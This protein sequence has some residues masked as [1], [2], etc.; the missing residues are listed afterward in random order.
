MARTCRRPGRVTPPGIRRRR[1][2]STSTS[3]T[4]TTS[5]TR[6]WRPDST[7]RPP[8][9]SCPTAACS[10]ASSREDQGAASAV[11]PG[12]PGLFL[13]ITNIGSAG[14]QQGIYDIVL[15]PGFSTNHFYYV[16]YTLGSPNH[17]RVSR[18]TANAALSTVAG[19]FVLYEDPQDAHAE[20]HGGALNFANDGKLLFTTGEHFVPRLRS[21]SRTRAARCTASTRTG[22]CRPTTCSTTAPG[23]TSTPSGREAC[24]TS[25]GP[26]TTRRPAASSATSAATIRRP[27]RRRSTSACTR[28]GLR[29][30]QQ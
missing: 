25:S 20:H 13:Q 5:R 24:A 30:A 6:S 26:T 15:D 8:S 21:R 1:H 17:D 11:H 4:T 18:F 3:P 19:E 14:V 9:S 12:E 10:S 2:S 23:R 16:F 27:R 28:R 7:C 29:L 22:P